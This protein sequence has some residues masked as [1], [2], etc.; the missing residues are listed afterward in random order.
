MPTPKSQQIKQLQDALMRD[1]DTM[2]EV[3]KV[4]KDAEERARKAELALEALKLEQQ[5]YQEQLEK[6]R[7]LREKQLEEFRLMVEKATLHQTAVAAAPTPAPA[8]EAKDDH[9]PPKQAPM[10]APAKGVGWQQQ[11][12][13]NSNAYYY[14]NDETGYA[15]WS[16][17]PH[18]QTLSSSHSMGP[19]SDSKTDE[20][21][22]DVDAA[23]TAASAA[24]PSRWFEY[25]DESV[26]ARYWYNPATGE[27]S[28]TRPA[29]DRTRDLENW[30]SYIDDETG[31]EYW[32]N[33]VTG[34]TTWE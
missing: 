30:V 32:Y 13:P 17:P 27:A 34:E 20:P 24:A 28:W 1:T 6:E 4:T 22:M 16:T 31:Q 3:K 29:V 5:K 7:E 21:G 23:A 14:V 10:P 15:T 11:W 12:D 33:V 8:L 2:E 9:P 25:W 19:L 18:L 26:N